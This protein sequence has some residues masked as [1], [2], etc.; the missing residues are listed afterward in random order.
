MSDP[1]EVVV[2]PENYQAEI[3]M[4]RDDAGNV[5]IKEGVPLEHQQYSGHDF[6][7]V[8]IPAAFAKTFLAKLKE[9]VDPV[10]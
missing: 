3:R 2:V 7:A 10:P 1:T 8:L 6:E 9:L 4:F 5:H